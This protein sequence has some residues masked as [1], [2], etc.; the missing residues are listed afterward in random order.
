[1]LGKIPCPK[2]TMYLSFPNSSII[3]WTIFLMVGIGESNLDGSK[4]PCKVISP[5]D[6]QRA[7]LGE[8]VQSTPKADALDLAI[9]F[10]ANQHPFPKT[11]TSVSSVNA[12]TIWLMYFHENS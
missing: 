1:M 7:F 3:S 6:R 2:F 10:K 12:S 4:F 11:I 8:H 9:S 5:P